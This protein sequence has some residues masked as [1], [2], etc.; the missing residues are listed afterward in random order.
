MSSWASWTCSRYLEDVSAPIREERKRRSGFEITTAGPAEL[1][2]QD[3][4]DHIPASHHFFYFVEAQKK[5]YSTQLESNQR[6]FN[7]NPHNLSKRTDSVANGTDPLFARCVTSANSPTALPRYIKY[8]YVSKKN[9]FKCINSHSVCAATH[10]QAVDESW[11]S[12]RV[13]CVM[14]ISRVHNI[15]TAHRR[16]SA[17]SLFPLK[18]PAGTAER[19]HSTEPVPGKRGAELLLSASADLTWSACPTRG[20]CASAARRAGCNSCKKKTQKNKNPKTHRGLWRRHDIAPVLCISVSAPPTFSRRPPPS[21]TE[22]SL[23]P[24]RSCQQCHITG[25]SFLAFFFTGEEKRSEA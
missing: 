9:E 11:S 22:T 2:G 19:D 14:S 25:T 18:R 8:R 21:P 3:Q 10:L 5:V 23:I 7:K 15:Q 13:L 17:S 12:R 20:C 1:S 24:H 16:R 6:C 4:P